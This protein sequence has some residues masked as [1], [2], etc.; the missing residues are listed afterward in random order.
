MKTT[1]KGIEKVDYFSK[2]NNR[3]VDGVRFHVEYKDPNVVGACV[4]AIF[5]GSQALENMGV[6]IPDDKYKEVIG[7]TLEIE[8]NKRGYPQHVLIS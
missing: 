4:E 8:Y 2:K 6:V 3:Q 1:I 7:R 5:I